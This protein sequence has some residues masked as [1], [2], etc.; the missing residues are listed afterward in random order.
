MKGGTNHDNSRHPLCVDHSPRTLPDAPPLVTRSAWTTV[1]AR[2]QMR[3]LSSPALRGPQSTHAT[4]CAASRHPLCVDHSPRTLPDA[5]PLVTRSAWT[6]VHARYQMRRLSSPALRGPQSTHATRYAASRHPLCVDHSPR[7]LPDAP[8]LVT[9]SAWT[10]VH[11]RYQMRRL[12]SPALRGP[13]STHATRCA[14]SRHPLCVDHSPRTAAKARRT[15]R[16]TVVR[17]EQVSVYF[18]KGV[19]IQCYRE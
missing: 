2:Y 14:A 10:T 13:Q 18:E 15:M 16:R 7:T 1:H 6:T 9:R 3:R 5:P 11:A 17:H 4:R 12:S 8:P 19:K